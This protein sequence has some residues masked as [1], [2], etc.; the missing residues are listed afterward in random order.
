MTTPS[1][2]MHVVTSYQASLHRLTLVTESVVSVA[3]DD[4]WFGETAPRHKS[5]SQL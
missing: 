3:N 1:R 5:L 2:A 4:G